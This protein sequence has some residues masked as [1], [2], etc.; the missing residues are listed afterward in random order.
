MRCEVPGA[1]GMHPLAALLSHDV[2][3]LRLSLQRR[4]TL[5]F[6]VKSAFERLIMP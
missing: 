1:A 6:V 2:A 5:I 4:D 3:M